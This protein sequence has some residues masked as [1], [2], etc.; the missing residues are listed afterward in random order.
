MNI[1][2]KSPGVIS[3][4]VTVFAAG[5]AV[6]GVIIGGA[7]IKCGSDIDAWAP[8]Y[9]NAQTVSVDYDFIR[10]RAMGTTIWIQTS[11]DDIETI[12]QFY[13]DNT[14]DM[15]NSRTR[16]LASTDW[17]VE[18]DENDSSINRIVLFSACGT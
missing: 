7:D 4:L 5:V 9:P 18:P 6:I 2:K 17:H 3:T 14:I 12:K 16:G 10:P 11:T 15:L 1:N 8:L 13:R